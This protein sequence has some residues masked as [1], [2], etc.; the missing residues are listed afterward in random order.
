MVKGF[1]DHY[2]NERLH[3][4]IGYIAPKD[5]LAGRDKEIFAERDRRLEAARDERKLRVKQLKPLL[6]KD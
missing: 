6:I 2:N 5:K 1:V 3:S 4:A